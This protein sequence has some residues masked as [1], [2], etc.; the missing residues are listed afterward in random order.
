M[1]VHRSGTDTDDSREHATWCCFNGCPTS[2]G[3]HREVVG[4]MPT[5]DASYTVPV[6]GPGTPCPGTCTCRTA[7]P[8]DGLRAGV[9]ALTGYTDGEL[10]ELG[11]LA[12]PT[13]ELRDAS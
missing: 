5:I 7:E 10:N 8:T 2:D 1:K 11:G 3:L 6:M 4:Q 13:G 9:R 12:E